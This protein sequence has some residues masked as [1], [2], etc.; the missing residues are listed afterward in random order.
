L[1]GSSLSLFAEPMFG[2]NQ[3][4]HIMRSHLTSGLGTAAIAL[5]TLCLPHAAHAQIGK[6]IV[7][8]WTLVS[9]SSVAADGKRT[10]TFGPNPIG[11]LIFD[12]TGRFAVVV[13]RPDLPK[14]A[15]K[16]FRDGTAD[17]YKTVGQG[18]LVTFGKYAVSEA[19]KTITTDIEGSSF[20][21]LIGGHQKRIV[22]SVTPE[23]LLYRNPTG[24]AG[25]TVEL[26]WKRSK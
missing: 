3:G 21:N 17:E 9:N 26:V 14:F 6:E 23:Q 11:T 15:G 25:D 8:A 1:H 13:M 4:E 19:D 12:G 10:D 24:A 20:P 18:M 2:I 22:V 5:S 7:G 16:S